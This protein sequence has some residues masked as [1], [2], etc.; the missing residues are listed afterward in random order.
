MIRSKN[1]TLA[2]PLAGTLVS[3][4][5]LFL[6]PIPCGD[7]ADAWIFIISGLLAILF[8]VWLLISAS[9]LLVNKLLPAVGLA[10]GAHLSVGVIGWIS[11]TIASGGEAVLGRALV[12]IPAWLLGLLVEVRL[13]DGCPD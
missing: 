12:W 8:Y 5:A 9:F 13:G 1:R 3:T 6:W 11:S 4:A 10:F 7:A 2:V